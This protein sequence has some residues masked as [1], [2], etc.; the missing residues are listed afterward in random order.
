M[1]LE[2]T[3]NPPSTP[4]EAKFEE[5]C[6]AASLP[7]FYSKT[8]FAVDP[9]NDFNSRF[10]LLG[11]PTVDQSI[12]EHLASFE[13]HITLVT[14]LIGSQWFV[15]VS[16]SRA[17]CFSPHSA[18]IIRG[19]SDISFHPTETARSERTSFLFYCIWRKW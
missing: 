12:S 6:A 7:G 9:Y 4:T 14:E 18:C 16:V 11:G 13:A 19:L 17:F 10:Q 2:G 8:L 1:F 15:N 3:A 5:R